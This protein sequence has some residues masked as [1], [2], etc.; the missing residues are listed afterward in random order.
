MFKDWTKNALI[1][2][3]M[4]FT[5]NSYVRGQVIYTEGESANELFI[6]LQGEFK[7][8]KSH[9]VEGKANSLEVAFIGGDEVFGEIELC[10]DIPRISTCKAAT[11]N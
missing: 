4:F 6:S 2:A 3:S 5:E 8:Y 1:K 10:K 11:T 9:H 7:F